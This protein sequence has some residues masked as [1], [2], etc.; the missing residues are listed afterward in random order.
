MLL[1]TIGGDVTNGYKMVSIQITMRI[2]VS[3]TLGLFTCLKILRGY[4]VRPVTTIN[5][6]TYSSL[7]RTM[8]LSKRNGLDE[9]FRDLFILIRRWRGLLLNSY[10]NCVGRA[11]LLKS[12][13][14]LVLTTTVVT[15]G[16]YVTNGCQPIIRISTCAAVVIRR[17][18][19]LR[20]INIRSLTHLAS[21]CG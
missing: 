15:R 4:G 12:G 19:S 3:S 11:G 7:K 6:L 18:A 1:N 5:Y 16:N 9:L 10:R 13:L 17:R 14:D 21:G 2:K 20:I 8:K